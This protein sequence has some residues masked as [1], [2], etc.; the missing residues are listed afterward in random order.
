M[1]HFIYLRAVDPRKRTKTSTSFVSE[2][3]GTLFSSGS[4]SCLRNF[5]D[6]KQSVRRSFPVITAIML[7]VDDALHE[8]GVLMIFNELEVKNSYL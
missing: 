8:E 5:L 4:S 3:S 7:C 1:K 6:W 2:K